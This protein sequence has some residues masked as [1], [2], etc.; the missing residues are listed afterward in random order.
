[1]I[2]VQPGVSET[3]DDCGERSA[4]TAAAVEGSP[5]LIRIHDGPSSHPNYSERKDIKETKDCLLL[6]LDSR[7]FFGGEL[8]SVNGV[9]L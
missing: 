4:A 5:G 9:T 2:Q 3:V 7:T 8:F 6:V 1:M